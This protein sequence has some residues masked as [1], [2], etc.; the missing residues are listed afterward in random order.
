MSERPEPD[1]DRVREA[2]R[3]HDERHEEESERDEADR[4]EREDGEP[5]ED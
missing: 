1:I 4:D 2:M 3:D 5:D